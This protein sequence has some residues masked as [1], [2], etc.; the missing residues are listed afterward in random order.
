MLKILV[1]AELLLVFKVKIISW[2]VN[3]LRARE[4]LVQKIIEKE[5][6]NILCIQ[7]LKID[8]HEYVSNF[9]SQFNYHSITQTQ[10]SYNGVSISYDKNLEIVGKA[11]TLFIVVSLFQLFDSAQV[12]ILGTLRG[13]QDVIIPTII[14]FIAY[15]LVGFQVSY[16]FGDI[17]QYKEIG[18]WFGL[19]CGLLFSSVFLYLRFIYLTNRMIKNAK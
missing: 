6:P 1:D 10:K 5:K 13:M 15:W 9:F 12:I 4:P 18:I 2:N 17:S 11:A 14:V 7:E 8:D 16:Y 19:L 3:S